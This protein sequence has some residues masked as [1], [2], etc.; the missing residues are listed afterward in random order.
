MKKK[1][2]VIVSSPMMVNFFLINQL[3]YLSISFN[4]TL[5][6][7]LAD[8]GV[9][10]DEDTVSDQIEII[11]INM[12]RKIS[13]FSDF[14]AFC[15]LINFFLKNKFDIVHSISPKSGLLAQLASYLAGVKIR[16]H[17]FTGQVW[18]NKKGLMFYMLKF[19]DLLIVKM[20]TNILVDSYSQR[21]FLMK[22]NILN[23]DNSVVLGNGSISGINE[24]R[25][26]KSRDSYNSFRE[27]LMISN[28]SKIIL[29]IG[30]LTKDKGI[31]DLLKA[32]K[33]VS[34]NIDNCHLIFVGPDEDDIQSN[35]LNKEFAMSKI[36]YLSY[37]ANPEYYMQVADVF[38]LPSLREGFGNVVLEAALC[39]IPSVVSNIYGLKDVVEKDVTASIFN[40]GDV[41]ELSDKLIEL[42][43]DDV[44]RLQMGVNAHKRAKYLFS[45]VS[46]DKALKNYYSDL[47]NFS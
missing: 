4:I 5:I 18:T 17:T 13:I 23:H 44:K 39:G 40:L 41:D 47:L 3:N 46:M 2:A 45:S 1:I 12:K 32:F 36:H 6:T 15:L 30:R 26:F 43:S 28:Q 7:G 35:Y 34:D 21:S 22:E 24:K 10:L 9:L 31:I 42:I 11:H 29:F 16:I 27:K 8:N 37:T 38:C 20:S 33:K 19:I 14:F 25:F